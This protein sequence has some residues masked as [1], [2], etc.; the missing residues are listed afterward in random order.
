[1]SDFKLPIIKNPPHKAFQEPAFFLGI[2][3]VNPEYINEFY[4]EYI[5]LKFELR[6][7]RLYMCYPKYNW[8][9]YDNCD[10]DVESIVIKAN[11]FI[12]D[13]QNPYA[14][15]IKLM[16]NKIEEGYFVEG[17]CDEYYISKKPNYNISHNSHDYLL[18]GY[19][20]EKQYF[21]ALGYTNKGIYE[22]YIIPYKEM[23][24]S[25]IWRNENK[26]LNN[27]GLAKYEFIKAKKDKNYKSDLTRIKSELNNFLTSKSLTAD[28]W[29]YGIDAYNAFYNNL[30]DI[31]DVRCLRLL[32]EHKKIMYSRINYLMENFNISLETL[33]HRYKE[34]VNLSEIM[35][36]MSLKYRI[37]GDID[38][39]LRVKEIIKKMIDLEIPLLIELHDSIERNVE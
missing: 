27:H 32:M 8:Y 31:F 1:M 35:F 17:F 12:I 19:N 3:L 28:S 18:Y 36:N 37:L 4:N 20:D 9:T 33:K 14:H 7:N 25:I 15:L 11:P 34:V 29:L 23:Y 22:E 26:L 24:D 38:I 2:L 10:C 30:P 6:S 21:I 16:R 13:N 5:N 39:K